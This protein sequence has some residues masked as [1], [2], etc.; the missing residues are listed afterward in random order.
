MVLARADGPILRC[1]LDSHK[2]KYMDAMGKSDLFYKPKCVR[3]I[4]RYPNERHTA[5]NVFIRWRSGHPAARPIPEDDMKH[6]G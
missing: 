3:F 2:T 4:G 1:T 6:D 5:H